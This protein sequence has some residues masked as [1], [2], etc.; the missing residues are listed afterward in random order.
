MT[1]LSCVSAD[2]KALPPFILMK[3]KSRITPDNCD[4]FRFQEAWYDCSASGWMTSDVFL[5]WIRRFVEEVRGRGTTFPIV[6][7]L[8]N[9][10]SHVSEEICIWCYK[11]EVI[12]Y[13]LH[14]NATQLYQPL[15]VGVFS[16]LKAAWK[17]ELI[18]W[19]EVSVYTFV[20]FL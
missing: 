11:H 8:D 15:D 10:Y 2:G 14:P 17:R 6:V 12:L 16:A 19:Q 1:V 20:A 13:A 9:H 3:L 4:W 7:F 5:R 18:K